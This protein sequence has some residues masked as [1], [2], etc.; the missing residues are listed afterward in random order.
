MLNSN[1]REKWETFSH[2]LTNKWRKYLQ[3]NATKKS[4]LITFSTA[5]RIHEFLMK[6][7]AIAMSMCYILDIN[8]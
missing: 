1:I 2:K 6:Q 4:F 7:W 8:L 5:D 3:N